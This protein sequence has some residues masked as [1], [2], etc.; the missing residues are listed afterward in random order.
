M[1]GK[2]CLVV[3]R[4]SR[5]PQTGDENGGWQVYSAD[6]ES[7]LK[8]GTS[9]VFS[10]PF[11]NV[12]RAPLSKVVRGTTDCRLCREVESTRRK[13][14][15]FQAPFARGKGDQREDSIPPMRRS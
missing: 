4:H 9:L 2:F 6:A 1:S 10:N 7:E 15:D 5:R 8:A 14:I 3:N 11:V 13:V 12:V